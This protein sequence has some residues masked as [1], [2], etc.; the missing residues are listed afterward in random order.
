MNRLFEWVYSF[1]SKKSKMPFFTEADHERERY[2]SRR[3]F[4]MDYTSNMNEQRREGR[5]EG[6]AEGAIH[7]Y[8]RLLG[9]PETP[10]DQLALLSLAELKVLADRLHSEIQLRG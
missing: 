3:K 6:R 8:E 4:Q 5:E 10:A 1:F 7:A 9:R 2:E